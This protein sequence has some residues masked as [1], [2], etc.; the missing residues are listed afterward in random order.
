MID[1]PFNAVVKPCIN[2]FIFVKSFGHWVIVSLVM[3]FIIMTQWPNDSMTFYISH[4]LHIPEISIHKNASGVNTFQH[5]AIS[6]STR[7]RGNVHL[8]HIWMP[9]RVSVLTIIHKMPQPAPV[10]HV[11]NCTTP[12]FGSGVFH[13]PKNNITPIID[14]KNII[15]YSAKNTN[16]NLKPVYS[17]WKPATSSD[18][19]SGISKGAR[20]LSANEAIK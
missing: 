14:T 20:L 13:A 19:A 7:N 16:A 2:L 11:A 15:E 9:T 5:K 1:N 8:I 12:I 17:V 3:R 4:N 18:S 10:V 6:W